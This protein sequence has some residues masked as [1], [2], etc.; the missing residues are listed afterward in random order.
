MDNNS[1][2][3]N[4][5]D[6][7]RNWLTGLASKDNILENIVAL[8]IGI[9]ETEGGYSLYLCGATEYDEEDSDW[10]CE[11]AY[12]PDDTYLM[13]TGSDFS[14]MPW[15]DFLSNIQSALEEVLTSGDE[16]IDSWLGERI[17]T[18]GFDDGDLIRV[19]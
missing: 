3:G 1:V 13:F 10:A 17:V 12:E 11:P 4:L 18:T 8:N 16:T 2:S 9:F 14:D 7:L 6:T 5:N 15:E 19:R